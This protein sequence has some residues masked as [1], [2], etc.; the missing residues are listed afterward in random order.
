MQL[1][2]FWQQF[3]RPIRHLWLSACGGVWPKT[4]L[5]ITQRRIFLE[6]TVVVGV[7][8]WRTALLNFCSTKQVNLSNEHWFLWI[9]TLCCSV[10]SF[11]SNITCLSHLS[12]APLSWGLWK[13]IQLLVFFIFCS[14]FES[15]NQRVHKMYKWIWGHF[16]EKLA[17]LAHRSRRGSVEENGPHLDLEIWHFP[18][19]IFAKTG[20]FLSF[21]K[22]NWSFI[23]FGPIL[24][25]LFDYL[26]KTPLL[27]PPL[28][29][30]SFDSQGQTSV[31]VAADGVKRIGTWYLNMQYCEFASNTMITVL[32]P[33]YQSNTQVYDFRHKFEK[34]GSRVLSFQWFRAY[35]AQEMQILTNFSK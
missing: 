27:T 18:I 8:P 19:T 15:I 21:A 2:F 1:V 25:N 30:I 24:K 14:H 13:K 10:L 11:D 7:G 17:G 3:V 22:K 33:L 32:S 29:K 28:G 34:Y 4:K 20:G 31:R 35:R 16:I 12:I 26:W 5:R 6:G 9:C 23:T